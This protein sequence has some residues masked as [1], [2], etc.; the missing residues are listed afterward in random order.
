MIK[1]VD[2]NGLGCEAF[3]SRRDVTA[4]ASRFK[5]LCLE[6]WKRRRS[7]LLILDRH[8]HLKRFS[9]RILGP[10][11]NRPAK[12]FLHQKNNS[13]SKRILCRRMLERP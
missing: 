12:L 6:I 13:T 5:R 3:F 4:T 7:M 9:H 1:V 10:I 11:S 2:S 8:H